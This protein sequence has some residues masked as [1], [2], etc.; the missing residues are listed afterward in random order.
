MSSS[1]FSPMWPTQESPSLTDLPFLEIAGEREE[2][3]C[4]YETHEL[5]EFSQ[6]PELVATLEQPET[7][8]G[9]DEIQLSFESGFA[10]GR[11]Q[12]VAEGYEK[13]TDDGHAIRMKSLMTS[14]GIPGA[15]EAT[16]ISELRSAFW[17]HMK[18]TG[19]PVERGSSGQQDATSG[20]SRYGE[21]LEL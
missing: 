1:E 8:V 21:I 12:G 6:E 14:Q 3:S 15:A 18:T 17:K 13:I 2:T 7:A 5:R 20:G 4:S 11:E 9:P 16:T 19:Y 10:D